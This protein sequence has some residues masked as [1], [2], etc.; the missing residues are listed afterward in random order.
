[1][2][3]GT[4]ILFVAGAG[5]LGAVARYLVGVGALRVNP[6]GALGTLLVNLIGCFCFGIVSQIEPE[7][8]WLSPS[9]RLMILTGFLGAFTTFSAYSYDTLHLYQTRGMPAAVA[10]VL[11]Q[12]V[13]GIGLAALGVALGRGLH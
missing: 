3:A 10:Y 7:G 9:L 12:N 2:T 11:V 5:A 8:S 1:M 13:A 4:R 6:D